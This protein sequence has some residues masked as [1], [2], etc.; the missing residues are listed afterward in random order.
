MCVAMNLIGLGER[1]NGH[2]LLWPYGIVWILCNFI[3]IYP[4]QLGIENVSPD[5]LA[6]LRIHGDISYRIGLI[7]NQTSRDQ[8]GN[9]TV[10]ILK[11][12]GLR[13]I[14]ILA[15]EHGFDGLNPAGQPVGQSVDAKTGIPIVSLYGRG[16]DHTIS[17]KCLD[18]VLMRQLDILVYDIQDSG[19]RH[20][21]YISTLLCALEAAAEHGKPIV[22]LDR[23]NF[24]GSSMEGPIVDPQ[25]KSFISIAPIPLRHGMTM[26]EL[27]YYFNKYVIPKSAQLY[28]VPMKNYTRIMSV[29]FLHSLS[30]NLASLAS[31]Y[32]YSF[33]GILGEVEPFHIGIGTSYP[34]QAIMLPDA[35]HFPT[36]EWAKVKAILAK[37]GI[38]SSLHT[39]IRRQ[40]NYTG[41]KL[42]IPDG[43]KVTSFA[44][45][46]EL[47]LFFKEAGVRFSYSNTF[48]KAVGTSKVRD[49]CNGICSKEAFKHYIH[50]SLLHFFKRAKDCYLYE[51]LP[52]IKQ[53]L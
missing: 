48:D 41:L 3:L 24:L 18:P 27:A 1:M 38:G 30:P 5:M 26:G 14:Y 7:S 19:M 31:I 15:P 34:F 2:P 35:H 8:Q 42:I 52:E 6:S 32:G 9:R 51:P 25:L 45:L 4:F 28:V 40:K 22:V 16:G 46:I 33:L 20:Y 37:Y 36:Y 43:K 12:K 47:L 29:P 50:S 39:A 49:V 44:L 53:L 13:I 11:Q 21:T 23:P 17:G 10:D